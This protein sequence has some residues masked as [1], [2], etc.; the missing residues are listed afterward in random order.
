MVWLLRINEAG[1]MYEVTWI[2]CGYGC[3][4]GDGG[5]CDVDVKVD[6]DRTRTHTSDERIQVRIALRG[7]DKT[8]RG[9]TRITISLSYSADRCRCRCR[10][11]LI[12]HQFAF[13]TSSWYVRYE[14]INSYR[15]STVSPQSLALDSLIQLRRNIRAPPLKPLIWKPLYT[16][17]YGT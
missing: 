3:G 16:V 17:R 12:L 10:Y 9:K 14:S 4:G 2:W 11:Q 7:G 13:Q 8:R 1:E 5:G 6:A 15:E